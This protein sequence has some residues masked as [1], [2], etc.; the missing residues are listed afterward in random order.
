MNKQNKLIAKSFDKLYKTAKEVT[1]AYNS[2]YIPLNALFELIKKSKMKQ[3]KDLGE[4]PKAYNKTLDLLYTTC[5]GYCERNDL[6]SRVPMIVLK[7][8]IDT[9]KKG[10]EQ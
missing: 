2:K 5:K 10:L 9:L 4:F 1:V 3:S 8:Y 7:T 6:N